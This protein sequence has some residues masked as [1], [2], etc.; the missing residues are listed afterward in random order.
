M[1]NTATKR[2][3]LIDSDDYRRE[4]RV[5]VLMSAGYEV[6]LRIDHIAA[7][8]LNHEADFDLIILALH[9]GSE[10][11]AF[12][13]DEL[14]KNNPDLP[15]LLL[16]DAG[17]LLP[18]GTLNLRIEAGRP[19]ELIESVAQLLTQSTHIRTIPRG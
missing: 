2:I 15:I 12:Y 8:R 9:A 14:H 17:V 6:E 16:T 4:T 7:V 10:K 11:A 13:G 18:E 1:R 19:T 3:L 5:R